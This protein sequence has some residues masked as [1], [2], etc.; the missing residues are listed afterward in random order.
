MKPILLILL[1]FLPLTIISQDIKWTTVPYDAINPDELVAK[2][3]I[4][5]D[6][7]DETPEAD[8]SIDFMRESIFYRNLLN[9]A[10][11]SIFKEDFARISVVNYKEGE[12]VKDSEFYGDV[13]EEIGAVLRKGLYDKADLNIVNI[14]SVVK[15]GFF[16]RSQPKFLINNGADINYQNKQGQTPAMKAAEKNNFYII[17]LL[18]DKNADLTKS[19][20]TG[21]TLK[22][23]AEN[24]RDKRI[25][26][27]LNEKI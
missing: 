1:L 12:M 14:T 7:G 2:G 5:L 10:I 3:I 20:Y 9:N 24:S 8:L 6:N 16:R 15:E 11:F 23:I 4:E 26:K 18:L 21:R 19:D 25:L 27:L 22:E 17:K 13:G